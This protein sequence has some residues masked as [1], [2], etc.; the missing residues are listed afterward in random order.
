MKKHPVL[1]RGVLF[2]ADAQLHT[3][4]TG[5]LFFRDIRCSLDTE[6]TATEKNSEISFL[7]LVLHATPTPSNH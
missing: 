7:V 3:I 1:E 6:K 5:M 4:C 2:V